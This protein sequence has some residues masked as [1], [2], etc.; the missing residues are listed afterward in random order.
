MAIRNFRCNIK[1]AHFPLLS[2]Y[3]GRSVA[4]RSPDDSDYIVTD[5]FSGTAANDEIGIAQ[6]IYMHNIM[7][8]SHGLQSVGYKM[9][10]DESLGVNKDFDQA[11][12]LRTKNEQQHILVPAAGRNYVNKS[13]VSWDTSV[14]PTAIKLG[15]IVTKAYV[16]QRT[17]I[18]YQRNGVYEYDSN[19]GALN[20]LVL[21]GVSA[22]EFDGIC[23]S[24]NFLI[25]YT[26]DTV[27][28]SSTLDPL[29]FQPSLSNGA[30][31][32]KLTFVRGAI[33]AVLP[34]HN[35]FVIYT[36]RNA[37]S[38]YW[39]GDLQ[40][41]WVFREIPG[42]SGITSTEHVS[43]DS[44]YGA[45]FAWTNSGFMQI[46][47][48][49]G[50]ISFPEITDFLTCGR[51]EDYIDD[52]NPTGK[53]TPEFAGRIMASE[54]QLRF[55]SG[56]ENLA[57]WK[58]TTPLKLKLAFI[59]SRYI[60]ISYGM[61]DLLTHI[62]VYDL[63][64]KRWGKLRIKHVDVFEYHDPAEEIASTV[65]H[66]FGVL[67]EDGTI[68]T[69]DFA[70]D[71]ASTDSILLFGRIQHSRSSMT[72]MLSASFDGVIYKTTKARFMPSFDGATSLPDYYPVC[73]IHNNNTLKVAGRLTAKNFMLKLANSFS[74]SNLEVQVE[75]AQGDR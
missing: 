71:V 52:V 64:L 16:S 15:G 62:L 38:A 67:Q 3:M 8:A 12:I 55:N 59:G 63:A 9:E 27:F 6:P 13:G 37:I 61:N 21:N 22:N 58:Y 24:N 51:L 14:A 49:S 33:V 19:T 7:P 35:G 75:S 72:T 32:S 5:S 74:I 66:S 31:S 45:H 29:D 50:I 65:K 46:S 25:A 28:W 54:T 70:H 57:I 18:C 56:G 23:Y 10:L 30:S 47:K 17:F 43:H 2:A 42:A 41:P 44:N 26:S 73:V 4:I 20:N 48:E 39:S 68:L 40:A 36:T 60:C 34:I 1:A 11:I 69:V 53:G